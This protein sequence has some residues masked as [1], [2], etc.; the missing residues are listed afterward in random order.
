MRRWN[1]CRDITVLLDGRHSSEAQRGEALHSGGHR[2]GGFMFR[3]LRSS[4]LAAV[5][6]LVSATSVWATPITWQASGHLRS[7]IDSFMPP[8]LWAPDAVPAGT[9][10]TLEITSDPDTPGVLLHPVSEAHFQLGAFAY[11]NGRR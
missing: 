6:G 10:W 3:S 11:G 8:D 5:C 4:L 1:S 7:S 9:P 2:V